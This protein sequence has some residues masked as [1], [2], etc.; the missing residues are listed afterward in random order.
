MKFCPT[1]ETRFDDEVM[2][3]CTKDGTPLVDE[4]QP[5]FVAMPSEGL[6]EPSDDDAG[7][8]TVVR[9]NIRVPP[10]PSM[11][12]ESFEPSERPA[13]RIVVPTTPE[14]V[15]EPIRTRTAAAYYPPPRQNTAK[16]VVLTI[17]GT[18]FVLGIGALL[19]WALQRARPGNTNLNLNA[20][21]NANQNVN[22]GLDTNFNFNVNANVGGVS[23]PNTNFNFNVNLKTPT[24]SPS[25]TPT[26][27][28]RPSPT[29]TATPGEEIITPAATPRP[30]ATPF[31]GRPRTT[32]TPSTA[33][34]PRPT[35]HTFATPE[36]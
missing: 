14:P 18:I 12:D 3:F 32:P 27:T 36:F 33:G 21:L 11:D 19:F 35:P 5:N 4:K 6:Q 13:D 23:T 7:E 15:F 20:N 9:S 10:P 1:C 26:P 17:V 25:T 34:T 22:L 24:P 2:R 31:D 29:P 16:V 8:V 30:S 28:P